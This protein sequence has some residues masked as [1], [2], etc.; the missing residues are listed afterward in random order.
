MN[1]PGNF[2]K[3]TL[4][5]APPFES[6]AASVDRMSALRFKVLVADD[7][8][9]DQLLAQRRLGRSCCLRLVAAVTNGRAVRDYLQ[10]TGVYSDRK[11]FPFPDLLLLDVDMPG[12]SGF[13]VLKWI[14]QQN[15]PSLRVV[16]LRGNAD[17]FAAK[18]A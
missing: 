8:A 13:E 6:V 14:K 17:S 7:S 9:Y 5:L 4:A 10:G 2:M 3:T 18:R 11:I 15:Y 12:M 16:M 1:P